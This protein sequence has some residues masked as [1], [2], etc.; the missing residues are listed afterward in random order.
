MARTLDSLVKDTLGAQVMQILAL[1]AEL[2]AVREALQAKTAEL[3][4]EKPDN[5]DS[6]SQ[7]AGPT[8]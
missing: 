7:K 5:T 1:T 2:D 6:A 3:C 4:G 8:P